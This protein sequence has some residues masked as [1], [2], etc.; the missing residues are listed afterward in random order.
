MYTY[1]HLPRYTSIRSAWKKKIKIIFT[2][3][4]A[5][6]RGYNYTVV[7]YIRYNNNNIMRRFMSRRLVAVG[8]FYAREP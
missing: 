5:Y 8:F 3:S 6:L 7:Y 1:G 4:N 2:I